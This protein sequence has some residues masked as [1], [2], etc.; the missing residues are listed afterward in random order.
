MSG[1]YYRKQAADLAGPTSNLLA[2]VVE[3]YTTSILE[4]MR[5][6]LTAAYYKGVADGRKL[7]NE[8]CA[9]LC[10]KIPATDC[11]DDIAHE[12]SIAH[13]ADAIRQRQEKG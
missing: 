4:E 3:K 7:E 11:G 12:V 5:G 13:C 2:S 10:E 6:Q 1:Q 8:E 9:R